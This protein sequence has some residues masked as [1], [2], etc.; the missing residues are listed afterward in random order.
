MSVIRGLLIASNVA[1]AA[2]RRK[3]VVSSDEAGRVADRHAPRGEPVGDGEAQRVVLG[4][5]CGRGG[6]GGD[7]SGVSGGDFGSA[8]RGSGRADASRASRKGCNRTRKS[9][10]TRFPLTFAAV[11][12]VM[13]KPRGRRWRL[14]GHG[15]QHH[16]FVRG[17]RAALGRVRP[18]ARAV[19][20]HR[21]QRLV[22]VASNISVR[23]ARRVLGRRLVL[24]RSKHPDLPRGRGGVGV[25]RRH[26]R[27]AP[28]TR[29][30]RCRHPLAPFA[31]FTRPAR[32][33]E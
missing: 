31:S 33:Q 8:S 30:A 24:Q 10:N 9:V 11:R 28:A 18:Y 2:K 5:A 20:V 19:R 16:V 3:R 27:G 22:V 32:K 21:V 13:L 26:L 23:R 29:F 15:G 12:A 25:S 4:A 1:R 14:R 6:G 17:R 7:I